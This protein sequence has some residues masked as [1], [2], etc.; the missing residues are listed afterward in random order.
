M[1]VNNNRVPRADRN[2][3]CNKFFG[4]YGN[5]ISVSLIFKQ[6]FKYESVF[7]KCKFIFVFMINTISF[8]VP[9]PFPLKERKIVISL[10]CLN[11]FIKL[12]PRSTTPLS[13]TERIRPPLSFRLISLFHISNY[14]FLLRSLRAIITLLCCYNFFFIQGFLCDGNKFAFWNFSCVC[15]L[16]SE[17][18]LDSY[19]L[20]E[21]RHNELSC[22]AFFSSTDG[23]FFADCMYR[24]S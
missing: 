22:F 23:I 8:S 7:H 21:G 4:A 16:L 12:S 11:N 5:K 9:F 18:A 14:I 24:D 10:V 3:I 17:L 20:I 13:L 2:I 15:N 6:K 1:N 19:S